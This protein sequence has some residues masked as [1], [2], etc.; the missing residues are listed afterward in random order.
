MLKRL[1]SLFL[2]TA[3]FLVSGLSGT[4]I[5]TVMAK[6]E[7]VSYWTEDFEGYDNKFSVISSRD[8]F[9]QAD[10]AEQNAADG[11]IY[12]VG[13]RSGGSTAALSEKIN[14]SKYTE[15]IIEL[16]FRLDACTA[17]AASYISLLGNKCTSESLNEALAGQIVTVKAATGGSNGKWSTITVNGKDI[18]TAANLTDGKENGSNLKRDTTGWIHLSVKPD[19]E[20]QTAEIVLTRKSNGTVIY[21]GET[22]FVNQSSDFE[23]I[24][25]SGGK[26]YGAAWIDNVKVSGVYNSNNEPEATPSHPAPATIAPLPEREDI[27][28]MHTEDL[29]NPMGID[30]ETPAFSWK[31]SSENRGVMQTGYRV[32]VAKDEA[33]SD[34]VWDSGEVNSDVSVDVRYGGTALEPRTRYYWNVT[35]TDN[36]GSHHSG[37]VQW[38][39]T[40]LMGVNSS[41]WNGAQWIGSP[42]T[43]VNAD[44][45]ATFKIE[46]DFKLGDGTSS[47]GFVVNARNKDNYVLA[48]VNL[49]TR[50]VKL[51]YYCD[52][53][54]DNAVPAVTALGNADGYYIS[55][56]AVAEGA[57]HDEHSIAI[58]EDNRNLVISINGTEIVN[59]EKVIPANETNKP[60][61]E[62]MMQFGFKQNS[63][64]VSYDN[65]TVTETH[66]NL[67]FQSDSFD[68]DNGALSSLGTVR[69]GK[70]VVENEFRL[71]NAVP[72]VNVRK[73]F[74]VSGEIKSARL[75]SSA[76]G[77]YNAYLNGNLV[78]NDFLNPGYTDYNMRVQYQTYDITDMLRQGENTIGATVSKGYYSGYVGNRNEAMLYG[79]QNSFI[80]QIVI[81]YAD[82]TTDT[83]VT[84]ST[85]QFT[86]K[87]PLINGDN[88]QGEMYDARLEFDWNDAN[89]G[90][91]KSCG[92]LSWPGNVKGVF[93]PKQNVATFELSAQ[94]GPAQQIERI[95]T[96]VSEP[97]EN[98]EGHFV[99]DLGQN[100]AGI[101]RFNAKGANGQSIKIRYGEMCYSGGRIFFENLRNAAY[102]YL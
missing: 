64:S 89:D 91:W 58:S 41:V 8:Y 44:S 88:M 14:S 76:R 87:G 92:V 19:F 90:R 77:F 38:F 23:Y 74:N 34:I 78:N 51:Y 50:L 5:N 52:N 63:G 98:P 47:A 96:P 68:N 70:L 93:T 46:T 22:D 99:Y 65:M 84:D 29:E 30:E 39:E 33:L 101:I 37:T 75:Y 17:N 12:G 21:S 60:R 81:D 69:D 4:Y 71:T 45:S 56:D 31:Q 36:D 83:I 27:Y 40:G 61:R 20:K 102:I 24:Y 18:K 72:G 11:L 9:W 16:D 49:D 35:V 79:K 95:L 1:F 3:V 10:S 73:S 15:N 7:S 85:W 59:E 80:G 86:D 13:S 55:T 25:I 97:Y 57:E 43:T 100:M 32:T 28:D 2:S 82:G 54:W 94:Q 48:D 53:A 42:D 62:R 6:E 26:T 66:Q 67:V